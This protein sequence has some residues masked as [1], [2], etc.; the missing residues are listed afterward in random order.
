[1]PT[2][3]VLEERYCIPLEAGTVSIDAL[4]GKIQSNATRFPVL[5]SGNA[6]QVAAV[7]PSGL[8]ETGISLHDAVDELLGSA[9]TYYRKN[10]HP[11]MF[12][13]VASPGLPTD[14]LGHALT[15]ALNQNGTGFQGAPGAT[16]IERTLVRWLCR[17][18][19][20]PESSDG[21]LVSGGSIA[22]L[23]ALATAV[24]HTLGPEAQERGI[25]DG[26]RPVI[27]AADTAHFSSQRAAV[28]LGLGRAGVERILVDNHYRMDPGDLEKKVEE[29]Q[30]DPRRRLCCVVATAGTTAM[31]AIDPLGK[32]A[33][34]CRRHGIWMHVDAAYGGAALLSAGLRS[35]LAG[36][37][38]ADSIT[39]DLH[40]WCYLSFDASALLYRRPE[41]ARDLFRFEAD[42]ARYGQT[43]APESH[44][45]FD[46]S[47]EVSRRNRA[48][49]AY[50]AWRHYGLEKLGQNVQHNAECAQY[51][52]AMA[53]AA[54]DLQLLAK[55]E[56][57]I[58]CFRYLPPELQDQDH[59]VDRLNEQIVESLAR[60]GHFLLSATEVDSRPV[61]RVCICS[62][63]TRA[64]HM[65]ALLADIRRIGAGLTTAS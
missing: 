30:A 13:Y 27:L 38:L 34:I 15:A 60:E 48:L 25:H 7:L 18:A 42:Y 54:P 28:L 58:C 10:A 46:L 1:M 14:P 20:L 24:H 62:H 35:R 56:L 53:E 39:I 11:G 26:P 57:S 65:D 51:L 59:K 61:L 32:I 43:G 22:N 9:G 36:I 50:L 40:K 37:G 17:L 2:P 6:R 21:L 44:R 33:D 47:P 63:T 45:F 4:V 64:H 8:P 23:S 41:H 52:A 5:K 3:P 16:T 12:S 49:P 19:G 29:I 55:P 31:G